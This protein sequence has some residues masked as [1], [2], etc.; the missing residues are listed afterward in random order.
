MRP[1]LRGA[2]GAAAL[3]LAGCA[4]GPPRPAALEA[5]EACRSCRMAIADARLAAQLVARGEE[6]RFFDDI[7]CLREFLAAATPLQRAGV[8]YVADHRTR[9]WV[10]AAQALYTRVPGLETPMGSHLVAH[11]STASR[12]AD[13]STRGGTP[14]SGVELFAPAGPPR[15]EP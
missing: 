1:A 13:E 12:D 10:P 9:A 7:G 4:S 5:G 2:W 3:L 15:G 8:V 14:V 11:A 6:P